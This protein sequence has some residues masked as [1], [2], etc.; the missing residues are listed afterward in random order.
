MTFKEPLRGALEAGLGGGSILIYNTVASAQPIINQ[1]NML[2]SFLVDIG[3]N[4]IQT[5]NYVNGQVRNYIGIVWNKAVNNFN[6]LTPASP[7]I[8]FAGTCSKACSHPITL[9]EGL[10]IRDITVNLY[11]SDG[12]KVYIPAGCICKCTFLIKVTIGLSDL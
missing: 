12:S 2:S 9:T 11:N 4:N 7:T 3:L 8:N 1:F 5:P 10:D 6:V